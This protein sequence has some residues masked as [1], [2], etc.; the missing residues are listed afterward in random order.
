MPPGFENKLGQVIAAPIPTPGHLGLSHCHSNNFPSK[1]SI[2]EP[3]CTLSWPMPGP[4]PCSSPFVALSIP[5]AAASRT[6]LRWSHKKFPRIQIVSRGYDRSTTGRKGGR[7]GH[8]L[9][10]WPQKHALV[11]HPAAAPRAGGAGGSER[12][13]FYGHDSCSSRRSAASRAVARR[14][15]WSKRGHERGI[16][17]IWGSV[18]VFFGH[19][20][21]AGAAAGSGL[22]GFVVTGRKGRN[23]GPGPALEPGHD[24]RTGRTG[25]S[26]IPRGSVDHAHGAHG[27]WGS[28]GRLS[29]HQ[30]VVTPSRAAGD[31]AKRT[32]LWSLVRY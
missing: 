5:R 4:S 26:T 28:R 12:A 22:H 20:R 13:A 14:E 2:H 23:R 16:S 11:P 32:V 17:R 15:P 9:P 10:L 30:N 8:P 6:L 19:D 18:A 24:E 7:R 1:R 31:G 21:T 27:A 25:R 29:W 3:K